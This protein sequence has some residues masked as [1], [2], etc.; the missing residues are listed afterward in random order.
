M[1]TFN[2]YNLLLVTDQELASVPVPLGF[3]SWL[4]FW[5][6]AVI[7]L[8]NAVLMTFVSYRFFQSLQLSG[9]RLPGYFAWL[10]ENKFS[11]WGRLLILSFLS[12]AALIIT[13]VLLEDFLVFKILTY[14]GLVFYAIFTIVYIVNVFSVSKKTPLKYTARMKR[15][16]VVFGIL[17]FLSTYF[18]MKLS[19]TNIP[20]FSHGIIGV[21]PLFVPIFVILSY[22]IMWPFE[23]IHNKS[24]V[25]KAKTKLDSYDK[26]IKIG[27]TGSYA[28]TSV[29]NI[30]FSMLSKKYK[31][32]AS[33]HSYNTPLGL[34]KTILEDLKPNTE[35]FI[36]EMGARY[37]GDINEL[38]EMIK[39]SYGIITA[40]SNQHLATFGSLENVRKTKFELANFVWC[41]GGK[42]FFSSDSNIDIIK[43]DDESIQCDYLLSGI[44][45][46]ELST[47][48]DIITTS[49]GSKFTLKYGKKQIECKTSLLGKH[50]VSNI[51]LCASVAIEF[52]LTL[53]EIA[54]TIFKLVPTAH[55]LAI[56]P[57]SSSL[58]VI[59]DAYNGSVEG[60]KAAL[61][62]I[63]SFD[64]KKFVITPGLVELGVEQFNSNFEFGINMAG[65]IDYCIITGTTNYEALANGLEFGGFDKSHILRAGSVSQAV[66]LANTLS[67]PGDVYL[68]EN[69]LPDNYA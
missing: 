46:G 15:M 21:T 19:L 26:L 63:S 44:N 22:L 12:C 58:I 1:N 32:V 48:G 13:N 34:S 42:M 24:F 33:P 23:T 69:D 14:I 11:D 20:Y 17:V 60:A 38:A 41:N 2:V 37:V 10:K 62:V 39:P 7:A 50:N 49:T 25:K 36:A 40:T 57:S 59:D 18:L 35:I 47:V 55:R 31:V 9:Y 56:V 28:K 66:E 52:G 51:L 43:P 30:L 67:A 53:E 54:D 8:A 16:I 4:T 45:N 5:L 6:V 3:D 64:G 68:F 27:I 29:K 61:E 65:V